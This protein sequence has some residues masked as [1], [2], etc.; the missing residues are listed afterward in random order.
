MERQ[1]DGNTVPNSKQ[2]FYFSQKERKKKHSLPFVLN[3][4]IEFFQSLT[5]WYKEA[6]CDMCNSAACPALHTR[7]SFLRQTVCSAKTADYLQVPSLPRMKYVALLSKT[8]RAAEVGPDHRAIGAFSGVNHS[9]CTAENKSCRAN[10]LCCIF[11]WSQT[12]VIEQY[13]YSCFFTTVAA[14]CSAKS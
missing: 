12:C 6:H 2:A 14:V 1:S 8:C 10:L 9:S 7:W 4:V 3:N 13:D 11:R 5:R